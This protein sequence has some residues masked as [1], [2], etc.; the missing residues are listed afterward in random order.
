MKKLNNIALII[1]AVVIV[2]GAGYYFFNRWN[3]MRN[4]LPPGVVEINNYQG[5][6]LSSVN[7][8]IE[9]SI[10]GPQ[11][12]D[13]KTY[14]LNVKG[15]VKNPQSFS[16]NDIINNFTA[17]KKVVTL[18]CVEGW[19]VTIL[20]EG[21]LLRDLFNQVQ[22]TAQAKTVIFRAV[23]GYSTFFPINYFYDNNIIMAY[24]QNGTVLTPAR[25]FPFQL[26][27]ESK[28]G[29][30]WIKWITEIEFSSDTNLPGYWEERGYSD[31]G[32]LNQ[33]FLK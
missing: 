3:K 29:Y 20:W 26:V 17:Q 25:G 19:S 6:N 31:T 21:I 5:K 11:Y 4:Q 14:Q 18:N 10:S 13:Q 24:K 9:N 1:L 27:A 2:I 12:V 30:K 33:P 7:D 28:W 16:Y 15:L 32:D 22:P 8:F 23:D